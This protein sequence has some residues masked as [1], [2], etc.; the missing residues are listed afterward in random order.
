MHLEKH[1]EKIGW[2]VPG[3][4]KFLFELHVSLN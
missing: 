2:Y 1:L 3:V 4:P